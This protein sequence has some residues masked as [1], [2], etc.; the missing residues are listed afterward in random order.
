MNDNGEAR[1]KLVANERRKLSAT[2]LNGLAVA[3]FA[4]GGFAPFISTVLTS[5]PGAQSPFLVLVVMAVCWMVSGAIH[6]AARAS[7]KGLQP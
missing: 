7:L 2:Y 1:D 6:S 3:V 4:V 5:G